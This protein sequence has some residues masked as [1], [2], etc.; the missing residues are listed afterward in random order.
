MGVL[1]NFAEGTSLSGSYSFRMIHVHQHVDAIHLFQLSPKYHERI[2][3]FVDG[4]QRQSGALP[5]M[6][7]AVD[8]SSQMSVRAFFGK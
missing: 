3:A 6:R 8:L 2:E 1:Y 4:S 7:P 5:D